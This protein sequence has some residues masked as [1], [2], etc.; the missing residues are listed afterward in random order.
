[1]KKTAAFLFLLLAPLTFARTRDWK[2]AAVKGTSET[3]VSGPLIRETTTIH[4]T[5]ETDDLILFLE[6]SYHPSSKASSEDEHSKPDKHSP[7]RLAV[8]LPTKIAI[9]GH[10]AYILD[11]TGA[12][13][14]MHILKKI[15][16]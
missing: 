12:E 1:M 15:K 11:D 7:P 5:V 6:Y 9:E 10:H 14:K 2:L 3:N 8:N 4:Y 16:K 13:V